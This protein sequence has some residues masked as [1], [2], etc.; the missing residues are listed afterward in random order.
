MIELYRVLPFVPSAKKVE[1]GHPLFFPPNQGLARVDNSGH[2]AVGYLATSES[3]AVAEKF[4]FLSSWDSKMLRPI[5]TLPESK[6][7]VVTYNLSTEISIFDMDDAQ[8]L[9]RLKLRPSRVVTRDRDITQG[10]ALRIYKA[11][12]NAGVSWWSFYNPDWTCVGLW[13]LPKLKVKQ[14]DELT[15]EH[16]SIDQASRSINRPIFH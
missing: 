13:S 14:I 4:G 8:N 12:G 6:W 7:V 2:Y 16:P 9:Q 15:L 1:L 5:K 3:C 10:W 11:G